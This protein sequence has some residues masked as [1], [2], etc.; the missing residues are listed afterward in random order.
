[1]PIVHF[2]N[3]A[4]KDNP[5]A[6]AGESYYWWKRWGWPKQY[7]LTRPKRWQLT[8]SSFLR[9]YWQIQDG[10]ANDIGED[11]AANLADELDQLLSECQDSLDNMPYELQGASPAGELLQE[12]ID[13]LEEWIGQIQGIDWEVTSD[14]QAAQ[15]IQ[16]ESPDL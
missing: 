11:D 12:R 8:G 14:E 10:L 2:V 3:K 7:S 15:L 6:K 9:T 13:G 1:M 16:S 5:V 4:R